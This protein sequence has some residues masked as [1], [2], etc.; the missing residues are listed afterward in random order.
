MSYLQQLPINA[1]KI[2][3]SFICKMT[4]D[5][6]NYGIVQAIIAMVH[7]LGLQVIAEGVEVPEQLS[8]L[9]SLGCESA[10]GFLF[11]HPL[12]HSGVEELLATIQK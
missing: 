7:N 6:S 9:K 11:Y 5:G 8:L 10:Q 2:D 1:I 4:Q 12:D 3:R